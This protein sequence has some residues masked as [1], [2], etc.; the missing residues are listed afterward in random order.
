MAYINDCSS[1]GETIYNFNDCVS[2]V[3][4]VSS[5]STG[6]LY[7]KDYV[8][9]VSLVYKFSSGDNIFYKDYVC[10]VSLV[11]STGVVMPSSFSSYTTLGML[12]AW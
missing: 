3:S 11:Y 7:F 9:G 8:S 12:E 6:D 4:L 2:G 10:G 1:T 5:C